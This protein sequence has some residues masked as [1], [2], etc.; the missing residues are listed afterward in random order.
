M[1]VIEFAVPRPRRAC[2][3][4][5]VATQVPTV[6]PFSIYQHI[7]K[8]VSAEMP[9]NQHYFPRFTQEINCARWKKYFTSLEE[10]LLGA[11][12]STAKTIQMEWGCEHLSIRSIT[13]CLNKNGYKYRQARKKGSCHNKTKY[14]NHVLPK[15]TLT[16]AKRDFWQSGIG[17]YLYGVSFAHKTN[18]HVEARAAGTRT[19]HKANEGLSHTAKEKKEGVVVRGI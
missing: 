4:N 14:C 3:C 17:F 12:F 18:S 15:K 5:G 13:R 10:T 19:W 8:L 1:H 11:T 7:K 16:T 6:R 9:V 2:A